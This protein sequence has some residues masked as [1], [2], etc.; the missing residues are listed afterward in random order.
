MSQQ[1][2]H[3]QGSTRVWISGIYRTS[4]RIWQKRGVI[5]MPSMYIFENLKRN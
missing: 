2:S 4:E 5:G 1:P 3:D